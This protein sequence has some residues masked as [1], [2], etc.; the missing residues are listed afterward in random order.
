MAAIFETNT[1]FPLVRWK[2]HDITAPSRVKIL[3]TWT[4]IQR[5]CGQSGTVEQSMDKPRI[6]HDLRQPLNVIRLTVA[7]MRARLAHSLPQAD[8]IYL[9]TKLQR[10][11]EQAD[12]LAQALKLAEEDDADLELTK[13]KRKG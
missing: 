2:F 5:R 9:E 8:L 13:T 4:A 7:N 1:V 6:A 3:T 11:E 10:I 12:R